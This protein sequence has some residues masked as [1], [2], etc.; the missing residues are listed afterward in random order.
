MGYN[1]F[2]DMENVLI[3]LKAIVV[4][5]AAALIMAI[6]SSIAYILINVADMIFLGRFIQVLVLIFYLWLWG[7]LANRFWDWY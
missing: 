6:P 1:K 4:S 7:F 2:F 5:I 3:T